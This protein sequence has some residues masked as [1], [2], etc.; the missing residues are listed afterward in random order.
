MILPLTGMDQDKK[1]I[2]LISH[3]VQ[4]NIHHSFAVRKTYKHHVVQTNQNNM[5]ATF[6]IF[7][8]SN[9]NFIGQMVN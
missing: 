4:T 3:A 2:N 6:T 7:V 8:Y 5:H 9:I 1:Y